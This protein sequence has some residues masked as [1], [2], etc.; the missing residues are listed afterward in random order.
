MNKTQFNRCE[1]NRIKAGLPTKF[2]QFLMIPSILIMF[3]SGLKRRMGRTFLGLGTVAIVT[4][5]DP[6]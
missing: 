4:R 6:V 3:L 5:L 1:H 2:D